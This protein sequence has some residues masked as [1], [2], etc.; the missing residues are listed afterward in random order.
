MKID[1]DAVYLWHTDEP[2]PQFEH[3]HDAAAAAL[4]AVTVKTADWTTI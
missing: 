4:A 2:D 1:S 3:Y